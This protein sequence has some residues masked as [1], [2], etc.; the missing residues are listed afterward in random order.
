LIEIVIIRH[1]RPRRKR[2]A[3]ISEKASLRG[4]APILARQLLG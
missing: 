1:R 2:R 4:R 3:S